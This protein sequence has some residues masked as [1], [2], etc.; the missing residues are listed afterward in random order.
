MGCGCVVSF[1]QL[2]A[3]RGTRSGAICG[4]RAASFHTLG[5]VINFTAM[6]TIVSVQSWIARTAL[7]WTVTDLARAAQVSRRTVADFERGASLKPDTIDMIQSALEKAGVIFISA[8]QGGPGARLRSSRKAQLSE[9]GRRRPVTRQGESVTESEAISE[10]R[11][12]VDELRKRLDR[13]TDQHG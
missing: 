6:G 2:Q 12:R 1:R 4:P 11:R 10:L 7:G 9:R 3:C 13:L 8:R 5:S